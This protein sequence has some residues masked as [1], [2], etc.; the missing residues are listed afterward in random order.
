[1]QI[2]STSDFSDPEGDLSLVQRAK[3][4]DNY[5]CNKHGDFWSA[6]RG[7]LH[8]Q[9]DTAKQTK[10]LWEFFL[11]ATFAVKEA[12]VNEK[13]AI[14]FTDAMV[15]PIGRLAS[16]VSPKSF[17]SLVVISGHPAIAED[18]S[19]AWHP[20]WQG[21][22]VEASKKLTDEDLSRIGA[23]L[24][25]IDLSKIRAA[26]L[27][28]EVCAAFCILHTEEAIKP[29]LCIS[30]TSKFVPGLIYFTSAP[31]I[32]TAESIVH[33]AAHLWLSRFELSGDLY[34]DAT[35][36]VS[37]PLRPDPR[38][39]SGLLHQIWVLS[40]LVS[41]YQDLSR[42][43]MPLISTNS[44]KIS[45]RLIQHAADLQVGL[46]IMDGN[47][48]ALTERGLNFVKSLTHTNSL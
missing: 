23:A 34:I 37:S 17:N 33:E 39:I 19:T 36:R 25:L 46:A 43:D 24:K 44:E 12:S 40:N 21:A 4:L 48:N 6:V 47:K 13:S 16:F 32:M 28:S 7:K 29:G 9:P 22:K 35:R 2:N 42:L 15:E 11:L 38:P 30:L 18:L 1:M 45:K 26:S 14:S 27:V 3:T 10:D 8:V 20:D 41:F 31:V 5:L